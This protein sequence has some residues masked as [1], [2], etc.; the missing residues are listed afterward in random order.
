MKSTFRT[1]S[2][3]EDTYNDLRAQAEA[4]DRTLG[5]QIRFL[6]RLNAGQESED[7]GEQ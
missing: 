5:G 7:A 3:S 2:I 1:V 6:L 4:A